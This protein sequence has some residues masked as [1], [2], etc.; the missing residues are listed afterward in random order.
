[1]NAV[2]GALRDFLAVRPADMPSAVVGGIAVSVR[3]EPR[4][5]RDLDLAVAVA[6]DDQA[7]RY[8]FHVRQHGYEIVS[9]LEQTARHRLSTVRLRRDGR[10]PIVD[11][12][13]ATCGIE[14]EIVRAAEPIEIVPGLIAE[15]A[16]IG[17]LIAM[18][19]VS[20]DPK[21][22]P[23]DQQDL[24]DLATVSDEREWQRAAA[25]IELVEQRGFSRGRD[26]RA[27]LAEL[28]TIVDA[29]G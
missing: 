15:V 6:D 13:F 29:R 1:L 19:L 20:R 10:G 2:E 7:A 25:A 21:R 4:F 22:R 3:T 17:H 24:V 26:L 23:R 8:F 18:K 12:L 27:G 11:L 9:A 28:R 14:V 5:T 16:Q